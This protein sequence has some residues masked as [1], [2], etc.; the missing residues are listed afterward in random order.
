[1][2]HRLLE[3]PMNRQGLIRTGST[4]AVKF[5]RQE[6]QGTNEAGPRIEFHDEKT[7]LGAE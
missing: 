3:H 2:I 1:M 6:K 7:S 5:G 4:V